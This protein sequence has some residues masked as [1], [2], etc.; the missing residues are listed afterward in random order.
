M[1]E[2]PNTTGAFYQGADGFELN[3]T[4][5]LPDDNA[6]ETALLVKYSAFEAKLD[7]LVEEY[8]DGLAVLYAEWTVDGFYAKGRVR[9]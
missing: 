9:K 5:P 4:Q 2:Q 8:Q 1:S 3:V 6:R 7:K